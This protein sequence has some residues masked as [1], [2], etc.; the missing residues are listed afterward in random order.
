M[1]QLLLTMLR[2]MLWCLKKTSYL[3]VRMAHSTCFRCLLRLC[4]LAHACK[5]AVELGRTLSCA[6]LASAPTELPC[7]SLQLGA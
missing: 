4:A 7:C 2:S 1:P 6:A 5:L 3:G